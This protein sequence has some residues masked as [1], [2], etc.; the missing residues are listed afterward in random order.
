[1]KEEVNNRTFNSDNID[2]FDNENIK[3]SENND[4]INNNNENVIKNIRM[5]KII[6]IKNKIEQNQTTQNNNE[7]KSNKS[8]KINFY[9]NTP[10]NINDINKI[11]KKSFPKINE[12]FNHDNNYEHEIFPNLISSNEQYFLNKINYNR[13]LNQL[14][15]PN[16]NF[17]N[18]ITN[19]NNYYYSILDDFPINMPLYL[20]HTNLGINMKNNEKL[21][22]ITTNP[23]YNI[24]NNNYFRNNFFNERE[25]NNNINNPNLNIINNAQI[26]EQNLYNPNY[27][28]ELY[29]KSLVFRNNY[30]KEY[31][32]DYLT[33]RNRFINSKYLSQNAINIRKPIYV[34]PTFKKRA[35][36]HEK[37]FNLIHKYY[38]GNFIMEEENEEE[39][40]IDN[41][42]ENQNEEKKNSKKNTNNNVINS[43]NEIKNINNKMIYRKSINIE[44][45]I[46][47]GNYYLE[48]NLNPNEKYINF[49]GQ[50]RYYN[51]YSSPSNARLMDDFNINN[52]NIFLQNNKNNYLLHNIF[53]PNNYNL[54]YERKSIHK[55]FSLNN[56]SP[57]KIK[58]MDINYEFINK[59]EKKDINNNDN[60]TLK[61][62]IMLKEKEYTIK[63]EN[64]IKKSNKEII[65]KK[66]KV[67]KERNKKNETFKK[68]NYKKENIQKKINIFSDNYAFFNNSLPSKTSLINKINNKTYKPNIKNEKELTYNKNKTKNK[69]NIFNK[70]NKSNFNKEKVKFNLNN[71]KEDNKKIQK[72]IYSEK[73]Q[74]NKK[75][76]AIFNHIRVI[77]IDKNKKNISNK[78]LK[79]E[80]NISLERSY[81]NIFL[82]KKNISDYKKIFKTCNINKSLNLLKKKHNLS[83]SSAK[84][85]NLSGNKIFRAIK[86]SPTSNKKENEKKINFEKKIILDNSIKNFTNSTDNIAKTSNIQRIKLNML[87]KKFNFN[88]NSNKNTEESYTKQYIKKVKSKEKEKILNKSKTQKSSLKACM[89]R[90]SH[91]IYLNK[92]NCKSLK[93]SF[94]N[95]EIN[96]ENIYRINKIKES[97]I[98]KTLNNINNNLSKKSPLRKNNKNFI[99]KNRN[100]FNTTVQIK[101]KIKN[102]RNSLMKEKP[103]EKGNDA[104]KERKL[105]KRNDF[106]IKKNNTDFIINPNNY[107][108]NQNNIK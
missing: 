4:N 48:N 56:N 108:I 20:E 21:Y 47:R 28:N 95:L 97:P 99:N 88:Y 63:L 33:N 44:E 89:T 26:K 84:K 16:Q 12:Y 15:I 7:I 73:R 96:S 42:K 87:K 70:K 14:N 94:K 41:N 35:R 19:N 13:K 69:N 72:I 40:N 11:Y 31:S 81:D 77:N 55:K 82:K 50:N 37:P 32:S 105:S 52:N 6:Q 2:Q 59:S 101:S 71:N 36:S 27:M 51:N 5:K 18:I 1:M 102:V 75:N 107:D 25:F 8:I 24:N 83:S 53:N 49:F 90:I 45:K 17:P 54:V 38:D 74:N 66:E 43:N 61:D 78:K 29:N 85:L 10:Q 100:V 64:N 34:L 39:T 46:N 9:S 98:F 76:R 65:I 30:I 57:E 79:I 23:N 22:N 68:N 86:Y 3:P 104:Y 93:G 92:I 91:K 60:T 106:N 103:K 80:K 62:E 67:K 58:N